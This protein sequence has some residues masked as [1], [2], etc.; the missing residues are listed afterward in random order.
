MSDD[1]PHSGTRTFGGGGNAYDAF[2]GRYAVP[3]APLFADV[4]G[5]T[6]PQRGLDVGCGTGALTGELVTRLGA[7]QV[8]GCDPAPAQLAACRSR[9]PAVDL[10][11]AP[12]EAL[13]FADDAFDVALAQLVIHFV[14]DPIRSVGEMTR[15]VRPGGR[16]GA[17]VWDFEG[18]MQMLVQLWEAARSLDADAPSELILRPFG[19]AGE[20][21]ALWRDAGLGDVREE[22]LTVETRYR[23]F[24]ELWASVLGGVGPAGAYV[25]SL[26]EPERAALRDAYLERLGSPDGPFTLSATARAVVGSVPGSD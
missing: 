16:V 9:F 25:T 11:E 21:A 5:V 17:T 2:M 22:V 7:E 20:L 19:R 24:E 1:D 10:R 6:A 15:V 12:A 18:G 23:D 14:G 8:A 13:P 4:A 26:G 3:L